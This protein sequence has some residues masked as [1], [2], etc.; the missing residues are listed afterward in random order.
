VPFWFLLVDSKGM[1]G[2]AWGTLETAWKLASERA[3]GYCIFENGAG[4]G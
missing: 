1:L 3:Y 4:V 2:C